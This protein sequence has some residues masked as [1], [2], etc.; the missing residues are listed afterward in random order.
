MNNIF[1]IQCIL[2]SGEGHWTTTVTLV[3]QALE[4]NIVFSVTFIYL[5][6]SFLLYTIY[7][8]IKNT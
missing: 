7:F 1:L 3:Y 4:K 2:S 6:E 5:D 8:I